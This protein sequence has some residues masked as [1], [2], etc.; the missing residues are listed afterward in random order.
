MTDKLTIADTVL[1]KCEVCLKEVPK[2]EAKTAEAQEYVMH[3]CGL[4]CYDEW[5]KQND[6]QVKED[7]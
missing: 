1:I 4:D 3:F 5:Q 2:S 7:N 6:S